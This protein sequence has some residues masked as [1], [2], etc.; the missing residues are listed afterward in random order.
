MSAIDEFLMGKRRWLVFTCTCA[1]LP[2]A[3]SAHAAVTIGPNPLPERN[4]VVGAGGAKIFTTRVAPGVTLAS[5]IDGVLVRWRVRRGEGPGVLSADKVTLR[6]LRS[7]GVFDE[8]TAMGTSEVHDV[9]GS[10][11][12]P[13]DIY[14][15]T[16][17]LPIAA[18]DTIGLGTAVGEF[19]Y[20]TALNASYLMRI[21]P[22]A[23]GQ[24]ATFE[25]GSFS[26]RYVLVNADVEPDCD[27]DG[28]GDETQDPQIASVAGCG[29]V[30][31]DTIAPDARIE[32]GP[33]KRIKTRKRRV[34]V[35][36]RFGSDDPSSRFEC[37]L[38]KQTFKPCSSPKRYRIKATRHLKKHTYS[39]RAIDLAGNVDPTPATRTFKVKRRAA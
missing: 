21:N 24:T 20:R 36:I 28:F 19:P 34:T 23:N 11:S 8:F 32:K 13:V 2:I 12:D 10:A 15:Y 1:V 25:A 26:D 39:V 4:G 22:L 27:R 35:S 38:D 16:T 33:K 14:E 37:K 18:G 30:A 31:A 6:I 17:R 3:A 7:T 5:P 9:P 29:F